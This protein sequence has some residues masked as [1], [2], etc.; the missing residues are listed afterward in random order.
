MG[1]LVLTPVLIFLVS[2]RSASK[3][4]ERCKENQKIRNLIPI[5]K[6]MMML[7]YER[8]EIIVQ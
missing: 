1:F 4:S 5:L 3:D 7:H 2:H 6:L 8:N